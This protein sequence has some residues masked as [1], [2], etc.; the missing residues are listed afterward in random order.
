MHQCVKLLLF[1]R[2]T[3]WQWRNVPMNVRIPRL[4]SQAQYVYA[5]RSKYVS[6]SL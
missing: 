1:E 4:A 5:F 3:F 6:H 2:N